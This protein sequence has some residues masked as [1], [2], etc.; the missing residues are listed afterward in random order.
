[1]CILSA[2]VCLDRRAR[3]LAR[4]F[5]L[6]NLTRDRRVPATQINQLFLVQPMRADRRLFRFWLG[7]ALTAAHA[8]HHE[9]HRERAG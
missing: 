7:R 5:Q 3:C 6:S 2:H 9:Q 8:A 4:G 1:M